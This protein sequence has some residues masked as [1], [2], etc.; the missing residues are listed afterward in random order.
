MSK[1]II[2]A[3]VV[4]VICFVA[5]AYLQGRKA[6]LDDNTAQKW[7]INKLIRE[8]GSLNRNLWRCEDRLNEL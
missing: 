2:V 6:T 8:I 7:E 5:T 3:S 4:A 1:G